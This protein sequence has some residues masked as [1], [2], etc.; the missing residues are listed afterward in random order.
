M[1]GWITNISGNTDDPSLISRLLGELKSVIS[2]PEY[3]TGSSEFTSP[4][5]AATN[6]HVP[7]PQTQ[8]PGEATGSPGDGSWTPG[9]TEGSPEAAG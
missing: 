2:K 7:D 3:G 9:Q 1:A 4:H 8:A 6:F 5:A